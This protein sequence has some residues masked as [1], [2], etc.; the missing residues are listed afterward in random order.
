[1]FFPLLSNVFTNIIKINEL[2]VIRNNITKYTQ[3]LALIIIYQA[4]SMPQLHLTFELYPSN[5]NENVRAQRTFFGT[6]LKKF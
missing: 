4:N 2:P 1:M 5:F 3:T 6:K